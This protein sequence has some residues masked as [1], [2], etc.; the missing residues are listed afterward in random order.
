MHSV[1]KQSLITVPPLD[2]Q[3]EIADFIR[4]QNSQIYS[5]IDKIRGA[6]ELV[7][8]Y[9]TALISAAVTGKINVR[10]LFNNGGKI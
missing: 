1:L 5:I 10:K 3:I 9:R 6:I 2:E 4:S 8:E 7:K